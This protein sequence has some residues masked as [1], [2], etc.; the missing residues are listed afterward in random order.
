M[1]RILLSLVLCGLITPSFSAPAPKYAINAV[2]EEYARLV[3]ALG[4]NDPDYVDALYGSA[5]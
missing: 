2:A 5:E 1:F 3:L 4:Q